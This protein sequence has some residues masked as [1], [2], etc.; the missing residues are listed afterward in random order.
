MATMAWPIAMVMAELFDKLG[1]VHKVLTLVAYLVV[2]VACFSIMASVYNTI[3]D[4]RKQFAILRA[5]G[6]SRGEIFR[7]ILVECSLI[8]GMGAVLGYVVYFIIMGVASQVLQAQTGIVLELTQFQTV[9]VWSVPSLMILGALSGILPAN[10]AYETDVSTQ[11]SP[12]S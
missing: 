12:D 1:W 3:H 8:A 6:A 2:L 10:K 7:L 4:R 5:L 9:H 11:L